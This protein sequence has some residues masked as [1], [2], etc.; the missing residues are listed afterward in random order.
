MTSD[1]SASSDMDQ[2]A[3]ALVAALAEMPT[4]PKHRTATVAIKAGGGYSYSYADISDILAAVR[5]VLARHG[6]ALFQLVG[7][8]NLTTVVMHV[9]GQYIGSQCSLP[10]ATGKELGAALTYLRRYAASAILCL[11]AD[12][13]TD[14]PDM[15]K[16]APKR[17]KRRQAGD[18]TNEQLERIA[19]LGARRGYRQEDLR[20]FVEEAVGHSLGTARE[21]TASEGDLVI[22]ALGGDPQ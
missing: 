18:I 15:P 5:P 7:T 2:L 13:D 17:A 12:E 20:L 21:L 8:D 16:A 11:A 22:E 9:S 19:E 14:A 1:I 10:D 3:P 4:I 6:L